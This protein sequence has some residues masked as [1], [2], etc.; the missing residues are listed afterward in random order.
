MTLLR[1]GFCRPAP[2]RSTGKIRVRANNALPWAVRGPHAKGGLYL[3]R[4]EKIF[5]E[6]IHGP[7]LRASVA[8]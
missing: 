3:Y 6:N 5:G 8:K 1:D 2:A 7:E 4:P